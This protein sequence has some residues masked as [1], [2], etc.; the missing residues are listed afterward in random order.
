MYKLDVAMDNSP[1]GFYLSSGRRQRAGR[2][3]CLVVSGVVIIISLIVIFELTRQ[4][5]PPPPT[6]ASP[7]PAATVTP[8]PPATPTPTPGS[9]SSEILVQAPTLTPTPWVPYAP[10]PPRPRPQSPTPSAAGCITASWDAQQSYGRPVNVMVSIRATNRCRRVLQPTDI[11]FRVT[12]YRN[13]DLI[14]TAQGSPFNEIYP[15]RETVFGIGLPGVI[16]WYDEIRVEVF[17]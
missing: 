10:E 16:D 7:T 9:F 4:E 15:G 8:L 2:S 14:Q 11:W 13:G 17:D 5:E 3:G 12:G 1:S 6:V